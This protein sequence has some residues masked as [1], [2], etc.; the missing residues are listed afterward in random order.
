LTYSSSFIAKAYFNLEINLAEITKLKKV[1]NIFADFL[2]KL[3]QNPSI[4][5]DKK[6]AIINK[7]SEIAQLN[8]VSINLLRLLLANNNLN[9]FSEICKSII[10]LSNQ[11][12]NIMEFD[13]YSSVD[14]KLEEL[15]Q[16]LSQKFNVTPHITLYK[17]ENITGGIRIVYDN[18]VMDQTLNQNLKTIKQALS[19]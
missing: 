12:N 2:I 9:Q 10:K 18:L 7:I 14:I 5:G 8:S 3:Q 16:R 6:M 11:A 15:K 1:G 17:D 13:V 19:A 4:S